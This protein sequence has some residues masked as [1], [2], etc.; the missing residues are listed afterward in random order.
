[1][2]Y[3][4]GLPDVLFTQTHA[5]KPLTTLTDRPTHTKR[6]VESI[7]ADIRSGGLGP[8]M[9]LLPR[10]QLCARF[11]V[12]SA[13][14]D[15]AYRL[16]EARGLIQRRAGSGVYVAAGV[17]SA[18]SMLVGVI[19]SLGRGDVE[20]YFEPLMSAA[21]ERRVLPA[22]VHCQ[23][24]LNWRQSVH[25]LMARR[26][27]AVIVDVEARHLP[28]EALCD[29]L[30]PAPVCFAHRW[31]WTPDR[32]ERAVLTDYAAAWADGLK[33]LWLRGN[34]RIL[35]LT[36]HKDPQP[37]LKGY[38]KFA[39]ET[40]KASNC[41]P[42]ITTLSVEEILNEPDRV[43]ALMGSFRPVA[44]M[45]QSDYAL[46]QLERLCPETTAM[47]R[48]GFFDTHY[49]S[50]QGLAFSS[51]RIDFETI[52][53]QALASFTG[54]PKVEKVTPRLVKRWKPREEK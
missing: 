46:V 18:S 43:K 26:P 20:D 25:D 3:C 6:I 11:G 13:V 45:G 27:D 49:S 10:R 32:P 44:I 21:A 39:A 54:A 41:T 17:K 5:G 37:Y 30:E 33:K 51:Y 28:L 35:Q 8:G 52:W 7:E 53:K 42:E 36:Q 47:E 19:S 2:A 31:E 24:S 12:S 4:V 29:A 22:V 1:M 23:A 48:I 14:V 15:S 16:L 38:L 40:L 50:R 9:R 34:D